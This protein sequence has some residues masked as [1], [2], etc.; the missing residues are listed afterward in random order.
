MLLA[1]PSG[2]ARTVK[3]EAGPA[4]DARAPLQG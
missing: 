3:R 1:D 2:L 4:H